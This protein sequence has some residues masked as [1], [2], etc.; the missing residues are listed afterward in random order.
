MNCVCTPSNIYSEYVYIVKPFF[1]ICNCGEKNVQ[2]SRFAQREALRHLAL[3]RCSD[4]NG[5]SLAHE[6]NCFS[7]VK[8]RASRRTVKSGHKI[9][10]VKKHKPHYSIYSYYIPLPIYSA[11]MCCLVENKR[12]MGL[13]ID[14]EPK[15]AEQQ[16]RLKRRRVE[17]APETIVMPMT[18]VQVDNSTW[19]D[20]GNYDEFKHEAVKVAKNGLLRY[21]YAMDDTLFKYDKADQGVLNFWSVDIEEAR[22]LESVVHS[23][24]A[25]I[26]RAG[27]AK[28]VKAVLVAQIIARNDEDAKGF[29]SEKLVAIVSAR[30]SSHAK[31]FAHMMAKADELAVKIDAIPK[32]SEI[33]MPEEGTTFPSRLSV[34]TPTFLL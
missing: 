10:S 25:K 32:F 6:K 15:K 4:A 20:R 34:T 9:S 33:I 19:Y 22:G 31:L 29:P 28:Y 24:L 11:N 12:K 3:R 13:S 2:R 27:R 1:Y 5:T 7:I 21:S 26:R 30:Y 23:E 16:K 14:G 8:S 17:F 18:S